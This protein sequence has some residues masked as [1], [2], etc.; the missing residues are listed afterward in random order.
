MTLSQYPKLTEV[1][2]MKDGR[3]VMISLCRTKKS[4]FWLSSI[5]KGKRVGNCRRDSVGIKCLIMK[6][7]TIRI[8]SGTTMLNSYKIA[9]I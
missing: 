5:C 4:S 2:S 6:R 1:S 7:L 9:K 3:A 8:F